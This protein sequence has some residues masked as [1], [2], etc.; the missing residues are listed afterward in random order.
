MGKSH[1]AISNKI[2]GRLPYVYEML[3][4][5]NY[6]L[7]ALIRVNSRGLTVAMRNT[8]FQNGVY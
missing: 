4:D 3:Q 2:S 7:Y 1:A 6:K 8:T 5:R